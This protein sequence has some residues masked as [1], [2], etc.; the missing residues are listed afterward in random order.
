[1]SKN[2]PEAYRH[3]QDLMQELG[4]NIPQTMSY[5]NR[6]RT[7]ATEAGALDVKT[8]EL[9]ALGIAISIRY[10]GS[11]ALHVRGALTAGA[12][13]DDIMET[14]G[15]AILM[16]GEPAVM[17]GCTAFEAMRQ[18]QADAAPARRNSK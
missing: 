11:V 9:I 12:T 17:C 7:K 3:I 2:Y 4:E 16:G 10:E 14:I 18:F 13:E 5:F 6:L 8:K 1:M 15:V